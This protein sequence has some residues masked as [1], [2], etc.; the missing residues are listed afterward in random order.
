MKTHPLPL[1]SSLSSSPI[2][3]SPSCGQTTPPSPDENTLRQ[4][5]HTAVHTA[6]IMQAVSMFDPGDE[7]NDSDEERE[8]RRQLLHIAIQVFRNDSQ[9][10]D[11]TPNILDSPPRAVCGH[12]LIAGQNDQAPQTPG[13]TILHGVIQVLGDDTNLH[14]LRDPSESFS[15]SSTADVDQ[16][17]VIRNPEIQPTLAQEL[18]FLWPPQAAT[19]YEPYPGLP[20]PDFNYRPHMPTP[21]VV[22]EFRVIPGDDWHQNIEGVAPQHD[23]TIPGLGGRPMDAPFYRY[24]FCPDYPEL[25]LSRGHNCPSHSRPLRAREDPYPRR[26]LTSKEVY[27]FFPRETFMPMVDFAICQE[28][29]ETLHAE[30]QCFQNAHDQVGD[31]AEDLANLQKLYNDT[32]WEEQNSLRALARANAFRRLEPCILHDAPTTSDIPWAVLNTGLDDFTNG[33][34]HAPEQY[35]ERCQWCKRNGHSMH[36]CSRNNQCLL[37]YGNGHQEQFCHTPHKRC[38]AGRVCRIPDN[39]P[40][41]ANTYCA[42]NIR[43]FG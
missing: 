10:G 6:N 22:E 28:G 11:A 16:L 42:L 7:T 26:V 32:H 4:I 15:S 31:L 2:D 3:N 23:Y 43:T 13:G 27:T 5:Q 37:C 17:L 8:R 1:M 29:V 34:K 36:Y 18:D 19:L 14:P 9:A 21:E 33:W 38:R 20:P 24:N 40:R 30:V 35:H 41:V 12:V 39:H 25:L